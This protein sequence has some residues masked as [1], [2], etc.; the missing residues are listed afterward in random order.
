VTIVPVRTST[1]EAHAAK[2]KEIHK[3]YQQHATFAF[4]TVNLI[5]NRSEFFAPLRLRVEKENEHYVINVSGANSV[6]NTIAFISELIDPVSIF[7]TLTRKN[8]MTQALRFLLFGEG[9]IGLMVYTV[10]LRYWEWTP[11][12]DVRPLI[13]LMSD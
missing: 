8:Q 4:L 10:L 3:Y 12:E 13:F 2:A 7:L 6:A 5:D 1:S 11:E 9:E